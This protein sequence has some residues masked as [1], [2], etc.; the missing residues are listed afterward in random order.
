MAAVQLPY[1]YY[2]FFKLGL[3]DAQPLSIRQN[4]SETDFPIIAVLPPKHGAYGRPRGHAFGYRVPP[5]DTWR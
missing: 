3:N 1:L 5:P 4:T 2:M